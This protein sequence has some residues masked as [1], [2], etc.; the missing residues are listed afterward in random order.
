METELVRPGVFGPKG[1]LHLPGPY[2]A[3]RPEF[4]HFL[5]EVIMRVEEETQPGS[6]VVDFKASLQALAD[7]LKA[8]GQCKGK[9][10]DCVGTRLAYV[11]AADANWVPARDVPRAELHGVHD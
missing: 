3:R 6:E 9:L 8:V 11:I 5:E 2:A 4:A 7:V 1:V 10:L